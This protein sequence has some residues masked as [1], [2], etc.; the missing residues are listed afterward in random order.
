LKHWQLETLADNAE[1]YGSNFYRYGVL[2]EG[3]H[4]LLDT[5]NQQND[6][7]EGKELVQYALQ[8]LII[9][10]Q[11]EHAPRFIDE[12]QFYLK[13]FNFGDEGIR[14]PEMLLIHLDTLS[15]FFD[16]CDLQ[17]NKY[18]NWVLENMTPLLIYQNLNNKK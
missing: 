12:C 18:V 11:E 2:K 14:D 17:L 8:Q 5:Y 13:G 4:T 1:I 3:I 6:S 16:N 9:N 15:Y 7:A 10:I